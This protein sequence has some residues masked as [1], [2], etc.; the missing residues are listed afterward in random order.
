ME[1][2]LTVI[3]ECSFNLLQLS[4]HQLST[5]L[6]QSQFTS[7][8]VKPYFLLMQLYKLRETWETTS[9]KC[10]HTV[11]KLQFM[12]Q[13][14]AAIKTEQKKCGRLLENHKNLEEEVLHCRGWMR[15]HAVGGESRV[16]RTEQRA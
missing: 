2:I 11:V 9:S 3:I 5:A 4:W 14:L 12:E 8:S 13:E 15:E 10:L 1:F 6:D 7:L 16:T